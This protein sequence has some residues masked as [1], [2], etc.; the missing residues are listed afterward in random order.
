[1]PAYSTVIR[2]LESLAQQEAAAVRAHG[3]DATTV[4]GL[5]SDNVQ[6]YLQQRDPCLGRVNTL[7]VGM[8]A[9]Y[10]EYPDCPV[11]AVDF[12]DRQQR[13]KEN[14]RASLTVNQLF[15]LIDQ[16]HVETT[17][18]LLLLRVLVNH[19]PELTSYQ[20]E[21]SIRYR[22]RAQ[23]LAMP[24]TTATKVHPLGT[25]GK[26]ETITTDL[27]DAVFDFLGQ[28]GQE[29]EQYTRQLVLF[30]GDGLTFEKA[31]LLKYI[32]ISPKI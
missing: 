5:I 24:S 22:S 8:A 1:M 21:V 2:T 4:G 18:I 13:I 26:N 28:V 6:N 30:C 9:T 17:G 7:T 14:T 19:I 32:S 15:S 11:E 10:V 23:K 12:D 29:R 27:K 3:R 31:V 25:S 16:R 20:K